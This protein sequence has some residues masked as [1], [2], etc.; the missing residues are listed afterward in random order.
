MIT[1]Q[2]NEWQ[3]IET[4]PRDGRPILVT[5]GERFAAAVPFD[6]EEPAELGFNNSPMFGG[7]MRRPN[8]DAGK[9]RLLW[10]SIGCS[11]WNQDTEVM[12]D[13]DNIWSILSPSHWM[14]LPDPPLLKPSER[15]KKS[16]L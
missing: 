15:G 2:T 14:P 11:A 12:S 1:P 6:Y 13:Y 4:A 10:S 9:I 16:K 7:D 3:P 8:P 5:D